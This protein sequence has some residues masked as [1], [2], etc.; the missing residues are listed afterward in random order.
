MGLSLTSLSGPI[1][2][3]APSKAATSATVNFGIDKVRLE[4]RRDE[5][6]EEAEYE[7][8]RGEEEEDT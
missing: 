6:G 1:N 3:W 7:N 5:P 8:G 4:D 2:N